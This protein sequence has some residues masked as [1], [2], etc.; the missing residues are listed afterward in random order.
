MTLEWA[1]AV[2][3]RAE[4]SNDAVQIL[5]VET[6]G[7]HVNMEPRPDGDR[8]AQESVEPV[9]LNSSAFRC[10]HRWTQGRLR[11]EFDEIATVAL[12]NVTADTIAAMDQCSTGNL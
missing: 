9:G 2:G 1:D 4:V 5:V 11:H 12:D 10:Q 3:D 7:R 8:G 6:E